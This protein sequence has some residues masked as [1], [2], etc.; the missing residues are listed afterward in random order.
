MAFVKFGKF[1]EGVIANHIGIQDEERS[2]TKSKNFL[3]K[4]ERACSPEGF[5]FDGEINANFIFLL[6]LELVS[7]SQSTTGTLL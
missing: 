7:S 5:G 1:L 4:L 2:I 3:S 6:V